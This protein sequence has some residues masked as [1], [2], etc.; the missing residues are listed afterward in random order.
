[1]NCDLSPWSPY[2]SQANKR[3][4]VQDFQRFRGIQALKALQN[5]SMLR[6][7]TDHHLQ[8]QAVLKKMKKTIRKDTGTRS[9]RTLH[10]YGSQTQAKGAVFMKFPTKSLRRSVKSEERLQ[11]LQQ[12]LNSEAALPQLLLSCLLYTSPSPRDS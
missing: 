11:L 8:Q 2:A 1:M 7:R 9:V 10:T 4:V 3:A 12:R 5:P 6:Q